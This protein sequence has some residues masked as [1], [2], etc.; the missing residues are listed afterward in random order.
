MTREELLCTLDET[1]RSLN[2]LSEEELN[3]IAKLENL[4]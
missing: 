4:S 1:E 2:T 3:R